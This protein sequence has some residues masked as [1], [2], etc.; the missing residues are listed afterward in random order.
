MLVTVTDTG[1]GMTPEVLARALDPFFTTK[2]PGKGTGLGL[3][4]VYAF[5]TQSQG[6]VGLGVQVKAERLDCAIYDSAHAL[7][8]EGCQQYLALDKGDYLLAVRSPSSLGA[9]PLRFRPVL[10]GLAG[11]KAEVPPEYLRDLFKR[12][13]VKP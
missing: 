8:G 9:K 12:I 11:A 10:L 2:E 4:Q 7:L 3:A 5:A 13:G 1:L 6:R